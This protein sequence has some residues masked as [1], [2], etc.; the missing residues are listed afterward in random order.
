[1]RQ[2]ELET[3]APK[4]PAPE[5][6]QQGPLE[7]AG[8]IGNSNMQR[9][10]QSPALQRSPAAA[11]L[12]QRAPL[13]RQ[14]EEEGGEEKAPETTPEAGGEEQAPEATPAGPEAG[15]EEQA[16]EATPEAGGEEKAE[17]EAA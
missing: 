4:K 5:Q 6:G 10:A 7:L 8:Q 11:G 14:E 1:M 13:A 15:G 3:A 2:D 9:V 12:I 17:E 16:P